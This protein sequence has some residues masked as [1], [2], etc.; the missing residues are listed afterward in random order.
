MDHAGHVSGDAVTTAAD[1]DGWTLIA[2]QSYESGEDGPDD[3]ASEAIRQL[4]STALQDLHRIA[5]A[6]EIIASQG[7][8]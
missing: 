6:L 1:I 5:D 7:P 2:K 4:I 8:S 3:V